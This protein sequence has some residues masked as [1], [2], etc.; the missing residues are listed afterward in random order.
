MKDQFLKDIFLKQQ[1]KEQVPSNEVIANWASNLTCVLYPELSKCSYPT[2]H[3]IDQELTRLEKE[4]VE[5]LDATR[6]CVDCDHV[7]ASKDFFSRLPELY[8]MLNTDIEAIEQGDPAARSEFEVIRAYPGFYALCFY[9][10]AH[11]LLLLDVPLLPRIL[12]EFAHSKTGIDIHPAAEI[13]K[14]FMIDHGT[15]IVIGETTVIGRH[16]KM[17]QG[18]TLGGLSISKSMAMQKRH[19]TI[20]DNVVIYSGATILGGDTVVGE[21]SVIG[22]NVWLTQSVPPGSLVFQNPEITIIENKFINNNV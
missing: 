10:I 6:A 18:V 1:Q 17:Y 2:I 19:P 12:T 15:G 9:R 20:E 14:Y 4:L 16:V 7:A 3:A 21:G 22:G 13:G 11:T 8:R 5:M